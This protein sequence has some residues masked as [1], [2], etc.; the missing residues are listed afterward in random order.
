MQ[1]HVQIVPCEVITSLLAGCDGGSKCPSAAFRDVDRSA[2]SWY[3]EAVDWAVAKKVTNG[4]SENSFASDASCTRAQM[5]TFL[6][7]ASGSPAPAN[8]TNNFVDVPAGQFYTDAVLWANAAG[9]TN[10]T[11][12]THFSPDANVT[13]AQTVTFL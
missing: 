7:R 13:C 4:V 11:D 9:I 5:V 12:S 10:G 2:E 8:R 1:Y 3:H 6:W